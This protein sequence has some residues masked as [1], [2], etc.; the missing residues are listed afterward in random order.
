MP[1]FLEHAA[2]W[3]GLGVHTFILHKRRYINCDE[4]GSDVAVFPIAA[5]S[6]YSALDSATHTPPNQ[7]RPPRKR[8]VV[9][10]SGLRDSSSSEGHVLP[11]F[12]QVY[13][14]SCRE[15]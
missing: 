9:F 6:L 3:S 15:I 11:T 10:V 8:P 5:G 7:Y 2:G 4:T 1:G 12:F 13:V 14:A